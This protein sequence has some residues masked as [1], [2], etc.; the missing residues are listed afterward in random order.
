MSATPPA[1]QCHFCRY[2]I[3]PNETY[4]S[5]CILEGDPAFQQLSDC[6]R[7][8]CLCFS[9]AGTCCLMTTCPGPYQELW[10]L[11]AGKTQAGSSPAESLQPAPIASLPRSNLIEAHLSL[12][13]VEG[14]IHSVTTWVPV[15]KYHHVLDNLKHVLM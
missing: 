12:F 3:S 6:W 10:E 1:K 5:Y 11:K 7:R 13:P 9:G 2:Q 8:F 14:K 4:S 15:L